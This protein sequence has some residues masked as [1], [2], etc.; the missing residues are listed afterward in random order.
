M[1][2]PLRALIIVAALAVIAGCGSEQRVHRVR[3]VSHPV[4]HFHDPGHVVSEEALYGHPTPPL[5]HPNGCT[6][7]P[8]E[9][10]LTRPQWLSGVEIT[11]YFPT[12]EYWFKGKL[13]SAPGIPGLHHV[14]WLYSSS[15]I[16]MEGTGQALDGRRYSVADL[17]VG[18]W[19]NAAGQLT[20]PTACASEWSRGFPVWFSGGW[21]NAGGAV[22]IPLAGGGWSNGVGVRELSYAGMTFKPSDSSARPYHT[23]AVDPRLIPLASRIYIPAYKSINGGWF[24]A[25]DTG[26]GIIGRHID[27]YRPP[28][29]IRDDGGRYLPDVSVYVIPPSS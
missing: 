10:P 26:G 3:H 27:V 20:T 13:V 6:R 14:D 7:H 11:E 23:V 2:P 17:G 1:S 5:P 19:V 28:T 16:A 18:G 29:P 21:R 8:Q 12:P 24:V 4:A 22:T 15:G 25:G 9:Q